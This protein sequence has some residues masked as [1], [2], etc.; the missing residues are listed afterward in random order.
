MLW[1]GSIVEFTYYVGVKKF[2]LR[3]ESEPD[4]KSD[5]PDSVLSRLQIKN[6]KTA[7]RNLLEANRLIITC[8][9]CFT[10]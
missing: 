10:T 6:V 7:R 5:C 2:M 3:S 4:A 9:Y 8:G 1:V